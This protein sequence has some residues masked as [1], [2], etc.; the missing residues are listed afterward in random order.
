MSP[1]R[2]TFLQSAVLGA[3][4]TTFAGES[5][6]ADEPSRRVSGLPSSQVPGDRFDPWIEVEADALSHNV[7]EVR[8]LTSGRPILAVIKNMQL[9][10]ANEGGRRGY[11]KCPLIGLWAP[12]AR[13]PMLRVMYAI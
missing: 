5:L 4:A 13:C 2:R 11:R 12:C 8:R 1:T 6:M 7:A 10:A 9:Y 3:V